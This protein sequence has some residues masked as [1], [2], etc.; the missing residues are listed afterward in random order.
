MRMTKTPGA[1]SPLGT[2][3][4]GA[5]RP[6]TARIKLD[7]REIDAP[8]PGQI[9][10]RPAWRAEDRA[11]EQLVVSQRPEEQRAG[12]PRPHLTPHTLRA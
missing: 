12:P 9:D 5:T 8:L 7:P 6:L 1:L 10:P 4:R 2:L 11:S 3:I